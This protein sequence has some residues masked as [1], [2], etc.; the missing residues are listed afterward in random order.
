MG[1]HPV[2]VVGDIRIVSQVVAKGE[3]TDDLGR[4]IHPRSNEA[5]AGG[6]VRL[7]VVSPPRK[8]KL[9]PGLVSRCLDIRLPTV[10]CCKLTNH[11]HEVEYGLGMNTG[12][13]R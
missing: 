10:Q 4:T 6:W 5:A 11:G 3:M 13:S 7:R 8:A 12:N 1:L 9:A 2:I